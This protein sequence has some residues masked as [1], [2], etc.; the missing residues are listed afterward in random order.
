MALPQEFWKKFRET[1]DEQLFDM[2]AHSDDYV[3]EALEAVRV[4]LRK[5]GLAPEKVTQ[6][7]ATTKQKHTD[8]QQRAEESLSWIL[9]VF[10]VLFC[11]TL[12][13]AAVILALLPSYYSA[14][15]YTKKAKQCWTWYGWGLGIWLTLY[16]ICFLLIYFT[17]LR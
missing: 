6:L 5:R 15:G 12:L 14:R 10:I 7:E 4:E 3:P 17:H 13:I 2:L 8:E 1:T 11:V 16:V 9:K